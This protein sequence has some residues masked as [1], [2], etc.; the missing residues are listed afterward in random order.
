MNKKMRKKIITLATVGLI[1]LLVLVGVY[2]VKVHLPIVKEQEKLFAQQELLDEQL[3]LLTSKYQLQE[4]M[5]EHLA[6]VAT[7]ETIMTPDYDNLQLLMNSLHQMLLPTTSYE[8]RFGASIPDEKD[9]TVFR[10]EVDLQF[11]ASSYEKATEIITEIEQCPYRCQLIEVKIFP[12]SSTRK[13][14][15]VTDGAVEVSVAA[16]FFERISA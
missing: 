14:V 11:T 2:G 6:S 10:R 1:L 12:E 15:A 5:A 3:I 4:Q 7:E 9:K 8:L 13:N 16:V